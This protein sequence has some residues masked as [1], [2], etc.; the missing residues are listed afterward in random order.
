MTTDFYNSK[1][2]TFPA[3]HGVHCADTYGQNT[4]IL[5]EELS[6]QMKAGFISSDGSTHQPNYTVDAPLLMRHL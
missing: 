3:Y 5:I 2:Y 1:Y 4:E 6:R